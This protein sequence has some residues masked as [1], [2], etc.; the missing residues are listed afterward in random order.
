MHTATDQTCDPH[1]RMI[2][3]DSGPTDAQVAIYAARTCP[4][5]DR[6]LADQEDMLEIFDR[7]ERLD[8]RLDTAI[9]KAARV[10]RILSDLTYAH[11]EVREAIKDIRSH[12]RFAAIAIPAACLWAGL[13]GGW[14]MS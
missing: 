14:L 9:T 1:A 6:D 13:L 5:S 4:I 2:D 10:G 12:T 11:T 3:H 7:I 8:A